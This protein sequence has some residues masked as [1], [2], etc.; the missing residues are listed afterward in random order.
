MA[1]VMV[2]GQVGTKMGLRNANES[3]EMTE[4]TASLQT[5]TQTALWHEDGTT[6]MVNPTE[7]ANL[8]TKT[9]LQNTTTKMV[10]IMVCG[11]DGFEMVLQP[12]DTSIQMEFSKNN[13]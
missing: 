5:G 9:E 3:I 2:Y 1:L 12:I 7:F 10:N 11:E 13:T 4:N 6:Q 8:G